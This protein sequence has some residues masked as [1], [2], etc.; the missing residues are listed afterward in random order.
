MNITIIHGSMRKGNTFSLTQEVIKILK[1]KDDVEINEINVNE[2]NLPFCLSCHSCFT[3]GEQN[4]PHRDIMQNVAE[5]IE[6]S[7]GIIL[8]GV[9]YSM[10][11]NAAMKNLIDHLSYYF[12]RP[13][14][15]KTKGLVVTTTAG[16]G[17]NKI[18]KYLTS[19]MGHWG[20]SN[21]K[22]V[23][24]KMQS[25]KF[26]LTENQHKKID[27]VTDEFYN[28]LLHN[29]KKRPT[30]ESISVHNAFRGMSAADNP[31]SQ[32][33]KQY[34]IETGLAEKIYPEKAGI[35]KSAVGLLAYKVT[36]KSMS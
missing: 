20:I 15:F 17:E 30:F 26:S 5:L 9:V 32:Y 28:A 31:V 16:A 2:L 3:K 6:S 33:D 21:V 23:T 14:L 35:I 29:K 34:W 25:V 13:R 4:C 10:H 12:H 1:M 27:K 36:K 8:S 22:T 7:D 24:C 19:T 11:L 18:A